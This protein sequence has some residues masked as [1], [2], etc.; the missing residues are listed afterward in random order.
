MDLKFKTLEEAEA[1]ITELSKECSELKTKLVAAEQAQ[2][3]AE[4]IASDAVKQANETLKIVP[5]ELYVTVSKKK[6]KILFGV[7]GL[8][9]EELKADTKK[10]ELL[11]KRGSGAFELQ[12]D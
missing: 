2:A 8:T 10:C 11:I 9:K 6:Y 4:E 1:F 7:D 3:A 5:Q 12:E